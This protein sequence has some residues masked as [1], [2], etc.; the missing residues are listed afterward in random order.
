ML[1]DLKFDKE[2]NVDSAEAS[3]FLH[4]VIFAKNH[5][6]LQQIIKIKFI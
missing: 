2:S 1:P 5:I 3:F 4:F 6:F